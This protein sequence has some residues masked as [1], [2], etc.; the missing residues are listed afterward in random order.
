MPGAK[1]E[2]Q[3]DREGRLGKV[4]KVIL[5]DPGNCGCRR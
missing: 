3:L 5:P 1:L 2:Q 4:D